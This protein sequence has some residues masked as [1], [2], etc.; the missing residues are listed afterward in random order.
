MAYK[1]TQI[2][3]LE[4]F[5]ELSTTFVLVDDKGIMPDQRIDK[6]FPISENLSRMI[7]NE[8]KLVALFYENQYLK[9]EINSD[10]DTI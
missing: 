6:T 7:S 9:N 5:D 10:G 4:Q 2:N 3:D 8:K 1:V